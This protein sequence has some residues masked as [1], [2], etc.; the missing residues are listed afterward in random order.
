MDVI[1]LQSKEL[2]WQENYNHVSEVIGNRAPIFL[3]DGSNATCIKNAYEIMISQIESEYFMMIEADNFI[4]ENVLKYLNDERSLKFWTI[5]KYGISYE[6][7]SIKIM[8]KQLV[9]KQLI[10]NVFIHPNFEVS[11]N[12]YLTAVPEILSEHRFDWSPRSEWIT[13]AKEIVKLYYWS[14]EHN[15]RQWM[16]HEKPRKIFNQLE[17]ILETVS[18]TDLFGKVLPSLGKLYDERFS[19]EF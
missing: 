16:A 13:I 6:H 9:I 17:P 19:K 2:N 4:N 8:N 7:G 1:F 5:N 18:F 3:I 10:N 12:L 11:A 15:F 14:H